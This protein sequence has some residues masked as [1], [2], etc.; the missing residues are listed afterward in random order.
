MGDK[1]S[2]QAIYCPD[3]HEKQSHV[4]QWF[5]PNCNSPFD[6]LKAFLAGKPVSADR[7][8][9]YEG[10]E[11]D[12]IAKEHARRQAKIAILETKPKKGNAGQQQPPAEQ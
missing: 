5:C 8:A 11:W 9:V 3:C 6:A 7:L 4:D 12:Q 2:V 1:P 10:E